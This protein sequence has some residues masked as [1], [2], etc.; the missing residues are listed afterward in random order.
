MRRNIFLAALLAFAVSGCYHVTVTSGA[1]EA[2]TVV[3]KPW[4]NSFV[5]GLVPPPEVN[6][7]AE[8]PQGAAKVETEHSFLNVLVAAITWQLYTPIHVRVTCASGPRR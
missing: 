3:D 4:N 7:R 6:T 8:C 1:P 5:Y 2:A